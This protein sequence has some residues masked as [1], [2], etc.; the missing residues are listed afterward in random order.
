M[1]FKGPPGLTS[2]EKGGVGGKSKGSALGG[3]GAALAQ[4]LLV[5]GGGGVLPETTQDDHGSGKGDERCAVAH[6]VQGL[7]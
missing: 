1:P 6:C 5:L 3:R 4:K 2:R 7:D